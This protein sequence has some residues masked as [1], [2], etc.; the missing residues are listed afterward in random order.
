M[1]I[2]TESQ[3]I[4]LIRSYTECRSDEVKQWL[5]NGEIEGTIFING[6]YFIAEDDVY[7][8]L[9]DYRWK[10]TPFEDGIDEETRMKRFI[11]EIEMYK[12]RISELLNENSELQRQ[13][14]IP[15]F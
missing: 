8:F 1:D 5:V 12:N 9:E 4:A 7:Q 14:G 13:L 2:L 3:A 11:E 15:P 6:M 10:G